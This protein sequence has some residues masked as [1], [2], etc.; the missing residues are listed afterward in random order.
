MKHSRYIGSQEITGPTTALLVELSIAIFTPYSVSLPL[1]KGCFQ[2]NLLLLMPEL[3]SIWKG[4][5]A[6]LV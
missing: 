3:S 6:S 1:L 5:Q 4:N 2:A